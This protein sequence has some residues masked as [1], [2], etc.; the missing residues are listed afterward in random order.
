MRLNVDM[1]SS[2]PEARIGCEYCQL[3]AFSRPSTTYGCF[4]LFQVYFWSTGRARSNVR[5]R[6]APQGASY[7]DLDGETGGNVT[8]LK[9]LTTYRMTV[10][11]SNNGGIGPESSEQEF[12]TKE[13]GKYFIFWFRDYLA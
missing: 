11:A 3:L 8:G 9:P 1:L 4:I 7:Q 5:R 13:G 12:S 10:A 2:L 6:R